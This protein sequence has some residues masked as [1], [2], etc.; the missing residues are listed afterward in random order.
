VIRF[1]FAGVQVPKGKARVEGSVFLHC[2][3]GVEVGTAWIGNRHGLTGG[4]AR[5]LVTGCRFADCGTGVFSQLQGAPMVERCV[6]AGCRVGAG[7][8]RFTGWTYPL[9]EPGATVDRCDFVGN[10]TGVLGSA[11]VTSTIFA[12][13]DTALSLSSFHTSTTT[14]T[15]QCAFRGNVFAANGVVFSG[16]SAPGEALVIEDAGYDSS[17]EAL[18][19]ALRAETPALPDALRLRLDATARG[20]AADGGDPGSRAPVV[21]PPAERPWT[22][23]RERLA[24]PLLLAVPG[25]KLDLPRLRPVAGA[26][27]AGRWW[28]R[29]EALADGTF[30][31]RDLF[32]G[33]QVPAVL[34]FR[35]DVSPGGPVVIE[36]NGDLLEV[37]ASLNGEPLRGLVA[38]RR[39]DFEGV[40][41]TVAAKSGANVLVLRLLGR[42]VDP[43]I[44][45]AI[46]PPAGGRAEEAAPPTARD[47]EVRWAKVVRRRDRGEAPWLEVNVATPLSWLPGGRVVLRDR[48]GRDLPAPG[49]GVV[50]ESRH[51]L[52]YGPL[53]DSAAAPATVTLE[54]FRS[55][56]ATPLRFPP[57]RVN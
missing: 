29:G 42:G 56:D 39:F 23:S 4:V 20:R 35:V 17:P 11:I 32:G 15:E 18:D 50:V 51:L 2:G 53:P 31:L 36:V 12:R 9:H 10:D 52:L 6:F 3:V 40:A 33:P 16:E 25:E 22:T 34:A 5:P 44:G 24:R 19:A 49:A 48:D 47:A 57:T 13:N 41:V 7:N 21:P 37:E 55:P 46:A 28:C 38:P 8:N 1:A 43:R 30:R 54:S 27:L 26:L 14:D 45:V